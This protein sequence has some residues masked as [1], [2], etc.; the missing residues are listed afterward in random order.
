E[1]VGTAVEVIAAGAQGDVS[2]GSAGSAQFSLI[3]TGGDTD[4][5]E[6]FD[7]W[8]QGSQEA[9]AMVVVDA[10]DLDI[11]RVSGLAI[12][13]GAKTVLRVEEFGMESLGA[14]GARN[15]VQEALEVAIESERQVLKLFGFDLATDVSAIGLEER[16]IGCDDD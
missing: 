6:S 12:D 1:P 11:V 14:A 16:H 15:Q 13:S 3:V 2:Y 9:G 4:G 5:G 7:R 8:N 10:L